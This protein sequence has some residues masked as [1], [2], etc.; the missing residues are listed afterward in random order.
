[1]SRQIGLDLVNLRN[2]ADGVGRF[3][4]Q[5]VNG[6][7]AMDEENEYFVFGSD[8]VL[9]KL[10]LR[11]AKLHGF[12]VKIP[13]RRVLPWNQVF[14][15][16]M[17]MRLPRMDILHSPVSVSPLLPLRSRKSLVTVHDLAFLVYPE[18]C[19]SRS[20]LWWNLAWP[21]SL[22]KADHIAAVSLQTKEDIVRLY[23]IPESKI[24]VVYPHV[25]FDREDI[26]LEEKERIKNKYQL[27]ERY[28]L[29]VGAPHK[30]KNLAGLLDAFR[31]LKSGGDVPHK[32]V[33]VGPRGW[34]IKNLISRIHGLNMDAEIVLTGY[35]PDEEIR[36]VYGS[37][38][39]FVFPSFYEGFGYPPLEA[40]AGGTPVVLAEASSLPEVSGM[41]AVYANPHDSGDLAAKIRSVLFSPETAARLR[42]DGY[43]RIRLFS[44]ERMIHGYMKIYRELISN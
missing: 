4:G 9:S 31:I 27:P 5:L 18:T 36:A 20:R 28:I 13:R 8:D 22:K 17:S 10:N 24:T 2:L 26:S 30:R 7:A 41:A 34:D 15:S 42:K 23:G 35:V 39:V 40:M 25:A 6:L 29:H 19:S 43:E 11:G 3:A 1:M 32:L 33:L 44:R 37:A 21:L 38:D 12:P 14:F 16:T